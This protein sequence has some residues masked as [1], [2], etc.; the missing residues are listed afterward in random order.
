MILIRYAFKI[1]GI[2]NPLNEVRTG[3]E[4]MAYLRGAGPFA[5]RGKFPLPCLVLLDVNIV[6]KCAAFDVLRFI[7]GEPGL[8]H[9]IVVVWTSTPPPKT[10]SEA[11]RCGA[12]SFLV[13]PT[14]P[15]ELAELS[16]LFKGYWLEK[17][18]APPE[19]G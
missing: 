1:A 2:D 13:K 8:R 6:G 5:D 16:R 4:A 9:L 10:V 11:Y 19:C 3:D 18:H 14:D 15:R 12:N 7:R 17:N